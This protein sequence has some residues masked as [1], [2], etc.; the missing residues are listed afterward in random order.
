[1]FWGSVVFGG[2]DLGNIS[3]APGVVPQ[4]AQDAVTMAGTLCH[5]EAQAQRD[6]AA[7]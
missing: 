4:L 6:T 2:G 3:N 7:V 5:R 1:V